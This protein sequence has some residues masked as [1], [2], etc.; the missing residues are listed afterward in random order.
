MS[1]RRYNWTQAQLDRMAE[2]VEAGVSRPKIAEEMGASV[3]AVDWQLLRLGVIGPRS[4]RPAQA[5]GSY[6]R[7]GRVVRRFTPEEDALLLRLEAEGLSASKIGRRIG[8]AHHTVLG[9][10]SSLARHEQIHEDNLAR[11]PAVP[12]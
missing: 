3:S 2:L 10:L 12:R 8:R 11:R 7:G 6:L 9:R 5:G 4:V 1:K